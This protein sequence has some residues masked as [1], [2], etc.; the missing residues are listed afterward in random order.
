VKIAGIQTV[1]KMR[2]S[3]DID[4]LSRKAN[5]Q[6]ASKMAGIP[7]SIDLSASVRRGEKEERGC[8]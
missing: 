5:A 3:S 2:N 1:Q 6:P 4:G 7:A 8:L